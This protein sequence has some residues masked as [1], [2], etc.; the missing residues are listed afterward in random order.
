MCVCVCVCVCEYISEK[1]PTNMPGAA[2]PVLLVEYN[3]LNYY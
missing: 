3:E 2:G 1:G